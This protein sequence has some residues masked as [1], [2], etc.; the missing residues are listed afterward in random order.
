[1]SANAVDVVVADVLESPGCIEFANHNSNCSEFFN[2]SREQ[3]LIL[4]MR[5]CFASS[6]IDDHP[7]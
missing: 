5:S 4:A 7:A 6:R 3:F 1:V 2:N